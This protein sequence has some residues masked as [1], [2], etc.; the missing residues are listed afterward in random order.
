MRGIA[1]VVLQYAI[2]WSLA[3]GLGARVLAGD[4][5]K[6]CT[7]QDAMMAEE[8]VPVLKNWG[9]VYQSYK[10][11]GH[12][13]DGALAEG[14]SD[15]ISRLLSDEWSSADQL[16]RFVLRDRDFERF[17]LKHIDESMSWDLP[18]K[19]R[20]NQTAGQKYHDR[21]IQ[22]LQRLCDQSSDPARSDA[23]RAL[24][25]LTGGQCVY[26]GPGSPN[27]DHPDNWAAPKAK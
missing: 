9:E 7:T 23:C 2:L 5:Q 22:L 21:A 25:D 13:D 19:I 3:F 11:Y 27:P 26:I 24:K 18:E 12:C 8:Q 14:Y 20:N 17:V 1:A 16:N 15:S 4:Y 6:S 10:A